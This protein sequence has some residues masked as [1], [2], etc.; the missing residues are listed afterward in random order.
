MIELSGFW[1]GTFE[2]TN[3]GGVS[4]QVEQ[5]GTR[6]T[7]MATMHEVSFG[8]YK[9]ALEGIVGQQA[10]FSLTPLPNQ[11][12]VNLGII[13]AIV[14]L[15]VDGSIK[16]RWSSSIGTNGVFTAKPYQQDAAIKIM[17]AQN[18][19]FLVHGHDESA[20]HQVARFIERIGLPLVILQEQM[21]GGMTLIEKFEDYAAKAGFAI[22]LITQ[23]DTGYPVGKEEQ[24]K[25]R[26]RQN[27]V[28]EMGY[29]AAKLGREKTF[30][31]V[32][33]DVEFPSDIIGLVYSK[34]DSSDGWK[35]ALA[36]ELK[37]AGYQFDLNKELG[38][39]G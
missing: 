5:T 26:P 35:L 22:V 8:V 9:Y 21:S 31:L 10:K 34:L 23:D 24:K 28:L 19:V 29:F 6:I 33:G 37:A 18:S 11:P 38:S 25:Y 1:T 20:K 3:F 16:G 2:G 36:K 12:N 27:V 15:Q 4:L 13:N 17:P 32:K 39:T 7:G 30:V 14:A